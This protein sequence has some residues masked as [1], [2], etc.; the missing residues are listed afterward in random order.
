VAQLEDILGDR[1]NITLLRWL[2]S[3]NSAMSGNAIATQLGIHQSSARQALERLVATGVVTRTDIGR[4]AGY[5]LNDELATV[6]QIIIPLFEG[7]RE[8]RALL[9]RDLATAARKLLMAPNSISPPAALFVALY[10]SVARGNRDYRDVDLLVIT[11]SPD[12][13]ERA[14]DTLNRAVDAIPRRYGVPVNTIVLPESDLTKRGHAGLVS[15][16]TTDGLALAG[17]PPRP[18]RDMRAYTS[19]PAANQ[20][21]ATTSTPSPFYRRSSPSAPPKTSPRSKPSSPS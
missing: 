21:A 4:T 7:E 3:V 18:L 15:Q 14:R 1:L 19:T 8:V 11:P 6:R 16:V 12:Q 5:R 10:G 20:R 2:A 13:N 9:L 17:T